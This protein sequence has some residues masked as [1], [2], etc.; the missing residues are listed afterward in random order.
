PELLAKDVSPTRVALEPGMR[1]L[2]QKEPRIYAPA[3]VLEKN[4]LD[5]RVQFDDGE[6]S[7]APLRLLRLSA[8]PD[9]KSLS[10]NP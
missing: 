6:V 2:A 3:R 10:L 8:T 9:G 7:L 5:F 1:V 4:G